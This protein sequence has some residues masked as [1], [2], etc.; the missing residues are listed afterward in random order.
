MK[1]LR[2]RAVSPVERTGVLVF[3]FATPTTLTCYARAHRA[4]SVGLAGNLNLVGRTM[5]NL[6]MP[7]MAQALVVVP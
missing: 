4:M 2:T 5:L 3:L 6:E 7:V 1:G